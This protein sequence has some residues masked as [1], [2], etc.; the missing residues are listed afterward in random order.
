MLTIK[1]FPFG[2][3]NNFKIGY[4]KKC[5]GTFKMS[6]QTTSFRLESE[7]MGFIEEFS[8]EKG[9]T[10]GEALRELLVNGRLM[11]AIKM[12]KK[13]KISIG[14]A[15]KIAGTCISEMIDILSEFGV[16][17]NIAIED[18]KE[19]LITARKNLIKRSN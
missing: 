1:K 17:S 16:K 4:Y 11:L 15:A 14:K 2:H 19:S 8:K 18:Y 7:T 5:G 12:Y 10:K 9:E 6:S 3:I 13:N